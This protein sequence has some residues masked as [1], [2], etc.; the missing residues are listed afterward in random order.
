M[1][2]Q[3]STLFLQSI[4]GDLPIDIQISMVSSGKIEALS[5][6]KT[7]TTTSP[8]NVLYKAKNNES[9]CELDA[10]NYIAWSLEEVF[11]ENAKVRIFMI[12]TKS[13]VLVTWVNAYIKNEK[14]LSIYYDLTNH[15]ALKFQEFPN[16]YRMVRFFKEL[17]NLE[18]DLLVYMIPKYV[19]FNK[20]IQSFIS[21]EILVNNNLVG[22]MSYTEDLS[23]YDDVVVEFTSQPGGIPPMGA[24]DAM[25]VQYGY[26]NAFTGDMSAGTTMKPVKLSTGENEKD[27]KDRKDMVDRFFNIYTYTGKKKKKKDAATVYESLCG[28]KMLTPDQI[29]Y[30]KDFR[31]VN[32]TN[33]SEFK[34]ALSNVI[35]ECQS[36]DP[37]NLPDEYLPLISIED[38]NIAKCKLVDHPT[39]QILTDNDG[40]FMIDMT[41]GKRSQSVENIADLDPNIILEDAGDEFDSVKSEVDYFNRGGNQQVIYDP[42][43]LNDL[44]DQ[45]NKYN[46]LHHDEKQISDDKS[47][48]LFGKSNEDRYRAIKSKFLN[49]RIDSKYLNL[50]ESSGL[51]RFNLLSLE[52]IEKAKNA[53]ISLEDADFK[54]KEIKKW[55]LNTGIYIMVPCQDTS[56]LNDL[57]NKFSS[58]PKILKRISDWK[59]L[60]NI[61]CNNESF[62]NFQKSIMESHSAAHFYPLPL[63]ES[64]QME[65]AE[66]PATNLPLDIPFYSPY[67]LKSFIDNK[68]LASKSIIDKEKIDDWLKEY[69]KIYNGKKFNRQKLVE[70]VS[71][72][73]NL[74]FK[75]Y[76]QQ[77]DDSDNVIKESLLEL[78]WNPYL[79]F[80]IDNRTRAYKRVKSIKVN[81]TVQ[82]L[83]KESKDL[84]VQFDNYGNLLITKPEKVDIDK[85][86][87]ESHRLLKSYKDSKNIDGIKFELCRLW[88][89]N[90]IA[91]NKIYTKKLDKDELK[92]VNTSRARILNDFNKYIKIVLKEDKNFNFN[93]FYAKS[94]FDDKQIRVNR[95]TLKYSYEYIKKVL[96]DIL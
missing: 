13:N 23:M 65:E 14:Y 36:F 34:S 4:L 80:T 22:K 70:W 71:T 48:A 8:E 32:L 96:K 35:K 28:R 66:F 40:Y 72:I 90:T 7:I 26:N 42:K 57:Y 41:T 45:Y 49:R 6:R 87:F 51:V 19:V 16:S 44:E 27:K 60:E 3:G 82:E 85:E 89:L 55:S 91:E 61:G 63:I 24:T 59:L 1:E 21:N 84:P 92:A 73:R 20:D 38:K 95:S 39:C 88:Y 12:K 64:V 11:K 76:E 83:L 15:P 74:T 46:S 78:G 10:L 69:T 75:L 68:P 81:E 18:E 5:T 30:D 93:N 52:N 9:I 17:Y 47:I 33:Q 62:Y 37:S 25:M 56:Q 29:E 53:Q 31:L 86:Y 50:V 2:N 43:D 67:E 77:V 79:E 54:F 58:M 94:K